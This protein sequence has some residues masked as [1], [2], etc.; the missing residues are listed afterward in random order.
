MAVAGEQEGPNLPLGQ[1]VKKVEGGFR[2][3]DGNGRT[4]W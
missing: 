2:R 1:E 3:N 4:E